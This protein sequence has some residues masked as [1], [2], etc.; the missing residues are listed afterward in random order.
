MFIWKIYGV[1]K[2][3]KRRVDTESS[4]Q[5]ESAGIPRTFRLSTFPRRKMSEGNDTII[6]KS[7]YS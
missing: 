1:F 2:H 5:A 3:M 6:I 4:F 7:V